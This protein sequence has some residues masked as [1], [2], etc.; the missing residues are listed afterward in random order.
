M[1]FDYFDWS[2]YKSIKNSWIYDRNWSRSKYKN[3]T[4]IGKGNIKDIINNKKSLIGPYL[5]N[6]TINIRSKIQKKIFLNTEN[7]F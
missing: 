1:S 2:S 6:K 4:V 5:S 7:Y 3:G